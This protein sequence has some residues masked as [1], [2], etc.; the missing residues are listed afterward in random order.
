[1]EEIKE[2]EMAL[3]ATEQTRMFDDYLEY[4]KGA[5]QQGSLR[6]IIRTLN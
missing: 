4:V 1:M 3:N 5:T 2:R 6:A